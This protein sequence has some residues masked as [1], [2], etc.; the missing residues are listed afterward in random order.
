M[1]LIDGILE[2][3]CRGGPAPGNRYRLKPSN[4]TCFNL[5]VCEMLSLEQIQGKDA[6]GGLILESKD[7][8]FSDAAYLQRA[9]LEVLVDSCPK[10]LSFPLEDQLCVLIHAKTWPRESFVK[11]TKYVTAYPMAR[12]LRN[13]KP[14]KPP[15]FPGNPLFVG[16]TKRL[17]KSRLCSVSDRNARLALGLLQ[18]VKRGC[19][20]VSE[21]LVCETMKKHR[22]ALTAP[23]RGEPVPET[24]EDKFY[25]IFDG[26]VSKERLYEAS[27][28][29][30]YESKKSDGGARDFIRDPLET[31]LVAMYEARPGEVRKVE[32]KIAP[33]FD[34]LLTMAEESPTDV[35]VAAVLE[36]LKVRLVSKGNSHRYWL[37]RFYQKDMWKH[38][39]RFPQFSLTGKP[40]ETLDLEKLLTREKA[41][42]LEPDFWVSG[43]YSAATDSLDIRWTK[44]AFERAL[45]NN[46]MSER[47]RDVLR[48]VLYEQELHY[49]K[50]YGIDPATQ[51]T[52]QL[53][54]S[55]L[56][57][58]ILC[59]VN[60][61]AYWEALEEFLGREVSLEELPVLVN[62]DDILFRATKDFYVIWRKWI[63]KVGFE[64]SLGKNYTHPKYLTVNSQL[65]SFKEG[66]FTHLG[67]LRAGL[68]TG[69]SRITGREKFRSAPIWDYYNKVVEGAVDPERA[70]KRFLHYHKVKIAEYT[71]NGTYNLGLPFNRGGLGFKFPSPPRVTFF[72]RKYARFMEK[73]L[74]ED[75]ASVRKIALVTD[76]KVKRPTYYHHEKLVLQPVM[77]PYEKNIVER[78]E[79]LVSLP[80]LSLDVETERPEMKISLPR[81]SALSEFRK[82]K[83]GN[84]GERIWDFPY[85]VMEK[86]PQPHDVEEWHFIPDFDPENYYLRGHWLDA[87]PEYWESNQ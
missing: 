80:V 74:M 84:M 39:Q 50:K 85:V 1:T 14:A 57:F 4:A 55:T 27:C 20:P 17:L 86:K 81:K 19:A 73:K 78:E 65:F 79:R 82:T 67:Y 87:K 8:S 56:S 46:L 34:E 53:M 21:E 62:G 43:D 41:L 40:V 32:G 7:P 64:L 38:L 54:G 76:R 44:A 11:Y 9:F 13:E 68:L 10:Y 24:S 28:S 18:G 6:V 52:G 35:M 69:Q 71:L 5:Q 61:V 16:R 83:N 51:T 15:G 3:L 12:F 42:G 63:A 22:N 72:Q 70:S 36:P 26:L 60:I 37:S 30:S 2:A 75:P 23:P 66:K 47:V 48:S 77:G 45:A 31:D 29:A 33:T 49:P 58:P 59:V 25:T